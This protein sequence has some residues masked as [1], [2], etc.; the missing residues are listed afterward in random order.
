MSS[1]VDRA[2][3]PLNID[4][5]FQV[6]QHQKI[7][8][9]FLVCRTLVLISVILFI[10][11][12]GFTCRDKGTSVAQQLLGAP[13][14]RDLDHHIEVVCS[15]DYKSK[16]WWILLLFSVEMICGFITMLFLKLW[17]DKLAYYSC[18]K[19]KLP[20][21][22]FHE[23]GRM[24]VFRHKVGN[25]EAIKRKLLLW[26]KF[27][28]LGYFFI[29]FLNVTVPIASMVLRYCVPSLRDFFLPV[30]KSCGPDL[31]WLDDEDF[32]SEFKCHF[33]QEWQ[34]FYTIVSADLLLICYNIWLIISI[35][36]VYRAFFSKY[37]RETERIKREFE[38]DYDSMGMKPKSR[39]DREL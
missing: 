15:T 1:V 39:A 34:L 11:F 25:E 32:R 30:S 6:L 3:E 23:N 31:F 35:V 14:K 2:L 12:V 38:L 7:T 29:I 19:L 5:K 17:L 16:N 18:R 33:E 36:F 8:N 37:F 22:K 9:S 28:S 20:L 24:V 27:G 26:M 13:E 10:G 21:A 4:P